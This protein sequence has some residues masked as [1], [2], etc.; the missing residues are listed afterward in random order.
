MPLPYLDL[1]SPYQTACSR[2]DRYQQIEN[3]KREEL[4]EELADDQM[5][6]S[7]IVREMADPDS[8]LADIISYI[9]RGLLGGEVKKKAAYASIE[10][11]IEEL[12]DAEAK[13]RANK[14]YDGE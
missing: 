13:Y 14:I 5:A 6:M 11:K 8:L 9:A 1:E 10:M 2:E 4:L 7:V 3:R 12:I